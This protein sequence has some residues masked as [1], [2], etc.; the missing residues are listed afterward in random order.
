M[1]RKAQSQSQ[2]QGAAA[3]QAGNGL[4]S[5]SAANLSGSASH[6]QIAALNKRTTQMLRAVV[7]LRAEIEQ[8]PGLADW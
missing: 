2:H 3:N 5:L 4:P 8:A 6:E 7:E 1:S